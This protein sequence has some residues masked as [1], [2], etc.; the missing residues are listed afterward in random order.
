M[1]S[2]LGIETG[3][4]N[5]QQLDTNCFRCINCNLIYTGDDWKKLYM[6]LVE[7]YTSQKVMNHILLDQYR[8]YGGHSYYMDLRERDV[9]NALAA[10]TVLM[11]T[12]LY[13]KELRDCTIIPLAIIMR[14]H[15]YIDRQ[16]AKVIIKRYKRIENVEEHRKEIVKQISSILKLNPLFVD[17][18]ME[19]V[20]NYE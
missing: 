4:C 13:D 1:I 9:I 18:L 10:A 11:H 14:L 7:N 3:Q 8:L 16:R 17:S 20:L 6:S 5:K 19:G 15:G 2:C 12:N